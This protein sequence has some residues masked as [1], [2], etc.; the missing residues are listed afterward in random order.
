M[1]VAFKIQYQLGATPIEHIELPLDSR[2]ELPPVLWA[3]QY[4]YAAPKL[5]KK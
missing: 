2:N 1:R 5:N 3:L 4:I